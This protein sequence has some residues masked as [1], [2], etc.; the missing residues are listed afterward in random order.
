MRLLDTFLASVCGKLF[1]HF[2]PQAL[3]LQPE[4]LRCAKVT[5]SQFGEDLIVADHLMN[6]RK[7][8]AKGI[9][10]DTGCFHPFKY[11]NTRL[12]NLMGWNG[13]NIDAS[14][15][16][17]SE[18]KKFRPNDKNIL[19]ALAERA[20]EN[21]FIQTTSGATS[22]LAH[23]A[24]KLGKETP[25]RS[26]QSV[27]TLSLQELIDD[28]H[29]TNTQIDF[30]DIDCEGIDFAILKGLSLESQRPVIIAIEAH[31]EKEETDICEYLLCYHYHFLCRCG[32]TLLFRDKKTMP[33]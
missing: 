24:V 23:G 2:R 12:L 21:I 30:L 20:E 14:K 10:I 27:Q 15:E 32:P 18:F 1:S 26:K 22:R 19:A 28:L 25:I 17:I 11:S 7:T 5:F 3:P 13:V 9:Y 6:F 8:S 29:L 31:S 16:A 33:K 4:D